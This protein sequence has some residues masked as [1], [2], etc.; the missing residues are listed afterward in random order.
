MIN[1][2][3]L[4]NQMQGLLQNPAQFLMT[5]GFPQGALQNPQQTV[6]GLLDNGRMS[7]QQF[8]EYQQIARQIQSLPQ[9]QQNF[10]NK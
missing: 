6:Q 5:K 1:I 9:F 3:N 8:N 2:V 4:F 10:T 7:Q